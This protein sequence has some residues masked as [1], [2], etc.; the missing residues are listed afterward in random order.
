MQIE[1]DDETAEEICPPRVHHI[2]TSLGVPL[3][4]VTPE[5]EVRDHP[6]IKGDQ[7]DDGE[8]PPEAE[9]QDMGE[10]PDA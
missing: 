4:L 10:P 9:E 1:D 2:P 3:R 7:P 5:A 8:D 6:R